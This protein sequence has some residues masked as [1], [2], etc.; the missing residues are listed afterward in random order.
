MIKTGDVVWHDGR[1]DY[2][3]YFLV[4]TETAPGNGKFNCLRIMKYDGTV[5]MNPKVP[6]VLDLNKSSAVT[7]D[8]VQRRFDN[9]VASAIRQEEH[10]KNH[11][12][13]YVK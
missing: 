11:L 2:S 7:A 10:E 3:G 9:N 12:M 5:V 4:G 13:K 1:T 6:R 8:D